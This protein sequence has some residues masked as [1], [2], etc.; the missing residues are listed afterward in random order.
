[1]AFY[2]ECDEWI[3]FCY[4]VIACGLR[5]GQQVNPSGLPSITT[6]EQNLRSWEVIM[7]GKRHVRGVGEK[8]ERQYEH[9]KEAARKSGRYGKR[10]EEVAARTVLKQHKDK[11]HKKGH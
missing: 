8:E 7:P 11:G 2:D 10:V 3:G 6:P 9:I 5:I 1:M 4:L